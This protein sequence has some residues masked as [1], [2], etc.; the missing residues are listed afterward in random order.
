MLHVRR[1]ATFALDPSAYLDLTMLSIPQSRTGDNDGTHGTEPEQQNNLNPLHVQ[2]AG[3]EK[4]YVRARQARGNVSTA[5]DIASHVSESQRQFPSE[6][7]SSRSP[8]NTVPWP[9]L[10]PSVGP[11]AKRKRSNSGSFTLEVRFP[12]GPDHTEHERTPPP[13]SLGVAIRVGG[14]NAG[15]GVEESTFPAPPRGWQAWN[16][17]RQLQLHHAIFKRYR[18]ENELKELLS[19]GAPVNVRDC[20]GYEPL[21]YAIAHEDEKLIQLLL[22]RGANVDATV[23]MGRS[24]LHLAVRN[25]TSLRGL[26]RAECDVNARDERGDTPL[27][28]LL[29]EPHPDDPP[30]ENI[31]LLITTGA[32][33]NATNDSRNSPFHLLLNRVNRHN[34]RVFK[35]VRHFIEAG[36]DVFLPN[37]DGRLPFDVFL[38]QSQFLHRGDG[39]P[40]CD[41]ESHY[42]KTCVGGAHDCFLAFLER[43]VD[44]D[45]RDSSREL[46]AHLYLQRRFD[47]SCPIT[48]TATRLLSQRVDLHEIGKNGNYYIH[49]LVTSVAVQGYHTAGQDGLRTVLNRGADSNLRNLQGQTPMMVL[50]TFKP[51]YDCLL[52]GEAMMALLNV[53]LKRGAD[54]WIRDNAGN[55]PIYQGVRNF[56]SNAREIAQVFLL[57]KREESTSRDRETLERYDNDTDGKDSSWWE[58]WD[59]AVADNDWD[60]HKNRLEI[61]RKSLPG[62]MQETFYKMMM[63]ILAGIHVKKAMKRFSGDERR[64]VIFGITEGARELGFQLDK[65]CLEYAVSCLEE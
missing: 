30:D 56:P 12:V 26:L 58:A 57:R 51:K 63:G 64:R 25:N 65:T 39:T 2:H 31:H 5:K 32:D 59:R 35:M 55:L 38:H 44:V 16:R 21:H 6:R 15:P 14:Q 19:Q 22:D 46:I 7:G 40:T 29:S 42:G 62:D 43:G 11:V 10:R 23:E 18:L 34:S 47:K 48:E 20:S 49:E 27:H 37:E 13:P 28:L 60:Q 45:V 53:F 3:R 33:V 24:A 36:A 52:G 17:H 61:A 4:E 8:I 54:P 1:D 41:D 9:P 50:L